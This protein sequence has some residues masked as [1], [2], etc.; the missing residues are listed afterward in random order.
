MKNPLMRETAR[1]HLDPRALI[2]GI[3]LSFISL[4]ILSLILGSLGFYLVQIERKTDLLVLLTGLV[5]TAFGGALAAR[6]VGK[7]GWLHGGLVG[8]GFILFS[9]L[10]GFIW[11]AGDGVSIVFLYRLGGGLATGALGGMIGVGL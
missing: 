10:I 3:V 8:L 4:G 11:T 5:S 9:Y 6:R 2:Y 7:W 1:L